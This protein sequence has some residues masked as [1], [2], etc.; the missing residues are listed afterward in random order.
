MAQVLHSSVRMTDCR[1]RAIASI[2]SSAQQYKRGTR[3]ISTEF[4]RHLIAAM[5]CQIHTILTDHGIQFASRSG[6]RDAFPLLFDQICAKHGIEHRSTKPNHPGTNGQVERMNRTLK[7]ATVYRCYYA[8]HQ[9]LCEHL[10][11]FKKVYNFAK[12]LKALKGLTP[13]EY[14]CQQWQQHPNSSSSDPSHLTLRLNT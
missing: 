2:R 3:P 7:K 12:R 8:I 4:L 9:Q 5:P 1:R 13:F 6:D 14:I 10:K 11:T